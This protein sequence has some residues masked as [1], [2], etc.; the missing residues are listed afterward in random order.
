MKKLAKWQLLA[1]V[2]SRISSTSAATTMPYVQEQEALPAVSDTATGS[3][4]RLAE[5]GGAD[6]GV[7]GSASSGRDFLVP[8]H[9][10]L[11][12]AEAAA[13]ASAAIAAESDP[14]GGWCSGSWGR[15]EGGA[16]NS[17]GV[18]SEN[19]SGVAVGT[20]NREKGTVVFQRYYH[21]FREQELRELAQQVKGAGSVETFFDKSNWCLVLGKA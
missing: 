12:R 5:G 19:R 9:V 16:G 3:S 1:D 8:W 21:L 17:E 11:H 14:T 2:A 13:A 4:A 20:V 15:S 6:A 7:D 18:M 10:P